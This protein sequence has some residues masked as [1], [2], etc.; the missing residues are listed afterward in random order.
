MKKL[1]TEQQKIK[2][3]IEAGF[4]FYGG[5]YNKATTEQEKSKIIERAL[6]QINS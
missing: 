6:N 5:K 2:Y 1:T 3:Q 4:G